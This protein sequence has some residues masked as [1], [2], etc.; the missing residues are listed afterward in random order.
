M[1]TISF[2]IGKWPIIGIWGTSTFHCVFTFHVN[3]YVITK[4]IFFYH[5]SAK[6]KN[7]VQKKKDAKVSKNA[8]L[9]TSLTVKP[10]DS[11]NC[12]LLLHDGKLSFAKWYIGWRFL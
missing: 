9:L 12:K 7:K 6:E 3:Q 8:T 11:N 2:I 10:L 1:D 5:K 4:H